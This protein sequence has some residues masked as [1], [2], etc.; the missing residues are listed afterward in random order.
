MFPVT[1]VLANPN[2]VTLRRT[3][4]K[5]GY[6]SVQLALPKEVKKGEEK[7]TPKK[8]NELKKAYFARSEFKGEFPPD[9]K[10][11]SVEQFSAGDVVTVVGT[12]KGKGFAGVVKRHN[13]SGGPASHGHRHVLRSGGSIGSAYPQ[14]V[15]KGKKMAGRMG[16]DRV[17]VK[18]L[19]VVAV[20]TEKNTIALKGA[21]PG[22][23]GSIIEIR[24]LDT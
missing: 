9:A 24:E 19:T 3:E 2:I 13:F 1:L 22:T 5:D 12:S 16:S 7:Q 10:T 21:V 20:D 6:A 15:M 23:R 4:E 18:N 11:V 17:T 14:H 8:P